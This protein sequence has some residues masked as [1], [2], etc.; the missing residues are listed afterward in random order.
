MKRAALIIL[1]IMLIGSAFAGIDEFYMFNAGTNPYT[2]I[3]GTAITDIL[4]DDALSSAV[5]IG[6]SFP[7]GETLFTEVKVSSN[8]WVGLGTAA[9]G[10][11]LSNDLSSTTAFPYIAPLWDDTSLSSGSCEYL[12]SG[13]AP[14]RIF[15]VQYTNLSWNYSGDNQFNF[16]VKF[17]ENGKIQFNYGSSTGTPNSPSASIGLN[18]VPG[19]TGWFFSVTPGTPSTASTTVSNNSLSVFPPAN[20]LF[21]F[22]PV[23]ASPNDL[24]CNSLTGNTTPSVNT[25]TVY[26]VT[27]RNR[28]TAAQSVYSVKLVTSTGTELVTVAGTPIQPLQTL[29][30]PLTWTPTTQGPLIL[31]GKVVLAGDSNPGNDQSPTLNVTVMPAGMNVVTIG[32]GDQQALIPVNMYYRNSLYETLLY[33]TEIGMVGNISAISLYNNFI[34]DLPNKPI[35]IWLGM[36][37]NA[38]LSAGWIPSTQLTPVFDGTVNFPSGQNSVMIPLQTVFTYTGGNLVMLVNRPMDT[39]YFNWMDYFYCQTVGENRAL[40]I[41]S[42]GTEFDPAAPPV[43]AGLTGQFP[44]MSLYMT[45]L[46]PDPIFI[47][48]P[49]EVLFGQVLMNTSKTRSIAVMNAGGGTLG[50]NSITVSGSPFFTLTGVPTLPQ[51][52]TT[53]Q[54]LNFI[55]HYA[56]TTAGVHT[57]MITI[58]DNITRQTHTIPL[59]ATCVDP[60]IYTL[61]YAQNFDG[62]TAPNLPLEWTRLVQTTSPSAYVRSTVNQFYTG[63]NSIDMYNY[64]DAE[65]GLYLISAPLAAGI[66]TSNMRVKFQGRS[67]NSG[68]SVILGIMTDSQNAASF[69][70]IQTLDVGLA[71]TQYV[72]SLAAYTGTGR[73]IAFKHGGGGTYTNI[74]LDDYLA[75]VIPAN[76]LA[77]LTISGNVTPSVGT[78]TLY[79]VPVFNWGTATQ[80][81]YLVKLYNSSNVELGSAAGT[82]VAA[83]QTVQVQVAWTP[84]VEGLT[85][86]YG[87]VVLTGDENTLNDQSPNYNVQVQPAGTL[88]VTIGDG[89]LDA[90]LP[91]DM[92]WRNSLFETIYY[93]NELGIFGS[94]NTLVFYNNFFTNLPNLPTKIWMGITTQNDLTAGWIPSTQLTLVFDGT[95]SYPS[96]LNTITI[97]LQTPFVYTGGN[98]VML[99]NRPMDTQY[100]DSSDYFKCQTIG[101]NRSLNVQSDG[102]LYDPAAPP[103]GNLSGTFPKTTMFMTALGT[104]PIFMINPT[105]KNYGTVLM[106]TTHNQVFTVTNAGGGPL[107]ISTI[108][109][110]GSEYLTLLGLPALPIQLTTG[111]NFQFTARYNPTVVGVH[112]GTITISDNMAARSSGMRS[113]LNRQVHT[114]ALSGNCIDATIT[115]LPYLQDFNAVTVPELPVTWSKLI[116][117]TTTNTTINST[118]DIFHS[119]ANGV[120]LNTGGDEAPNMLLISPPVVSTTPLNTMRAK[121]WARGS[122]E[123]SLTVGVM[124]NPQDAATFVQLGLI[125]LNPLWTEYVINFSAYTGTGHYVAFKHGAGGMYRSIYLDD[126]MLEVTPQNDLAA[127]SLLGN[128][129]PSV[130]APSIYTVNVFNWGLQAQNTYTVKL[131]KQDGTEIGSAAGVNINPGQT[132]QV[133]VS[134]TPAQEGAVTI[135]AKTV[136][137]ADQNTLNDQSPNFNVVVQPQGLVTITIGAGDQEARIPVDFWWRNSLFET[138]YYPAELS[139]TIGIIYGVSFYNNFPDALMAMPTKVWL[140][141]TTQADLSAG[142]IPSSQ[143][144][145]VFDGTVNYPA[146][147]NTVNISFTTPYMYL[148]GG[149]LVMMVNRPMDTQYYNSGS[150]FKCQTVGETRSLSIYSDSDDFSPSA[151]PDGA[152]NSGQFPKTTFYVIPGGVGHITGTVL[153]AGSQPLADVTV[154][155]QTG[156]YSAITDAQGHYA[157]QNIISDEYNVSFSKFGYVSQTLAANIQEDQTLTLNVTLAQMA[158]VNVTGTILA[159]DTSA[160]LNGAAIHLSGYQDYTANTNATGAFTIPGVYA[161]NEY[162]YS[163]MCPG[164]T[165]ANGTVNVGGTNHNMGSITLLEVAYAPNNVVATAVQTGQQVNLTWEA[166]NPN[167]TELTEGFELTT[168]PPLDWTV[169]VTNTGPA[170]TSGVF[171]TWCRFGNI[172]IGTTPVAPPE[173]TWQAGLWWSYEHQNEWLITPTFNCPPSAYLNFASYVFLGSTAG[174]HYYVK[175]STD[176]GISWTV[177][178]DASAQTGGWNYYA[179]PINIDLSAY[180]GQQL[181]IAWHAVDP[182]SNDGLWYVWFMDDIYIGNARETVRFAWSE[183]Q[184]VSATSRNAR[185]GIIATTQP[186]RHRENGS[187]KPELAL[188]L[189]HQI[190]SNAQDN[191]FLTGYKVWR[192]MQGQEANSAVWTSITPNTITATALQDSQWGSLPDGAYRWAVKAVYTNGV[193]SV[194]SFSNTITYLTETGMI[195]GVVRQQN[196]QPIPGAVITAGDYTATTNNS[197]AYSIVAETGVYSVLVSANNYQGQTVENVLVV[198]NQT[199]TVNFVLIPGS[200]SDDPSAPVAKTELLGNYPNP[201]NPSTTISYALKDPVPV[202]LVIYNLKGQKVK[203]LLRENQSSGRYQVIWNGKDE[204]DRPVGSGVYYYVMKAGAYQSMRKMLLVE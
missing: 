44:K 151:P 82:S 173:G 23:V 77:A 78:Q 66:P 104:D 191:R 184:S 73:Y 148:T 54:A 138:M 46:S 168:F 137:A 162:S 169:N 181:K 196:N 33:P 198:A 119:P 24:T 155:F 47:Y 88:S 180:G 156:G 182:P 189:S 166:P 202:E 176:N 142:W 40:N 11:N 59:S 120:L 127:I 70:P 102:T 164:Y 55:L 199:T 60:T 109:Y 95:V 74:Y 132:V 63:P 187:L 114:V 121:F 141:T 21:E 36:T 163:I 160:G 106:N 10:S 133:P 79:T 204:G 186:S 45:P 69:T 188:P 15:T 61:P 145:L 203:T 125:T 115:T 64:D 48:N 32:A 153:G 89:S 19:G 161:N 175:V 5:P 149:N 128:A 16:Q 165:A 172:T 52:L 144:Q 107:D 105:S 35:K 18:M 86:I 134:W 67:N 80:T 56:P 130:G 3:T 183:M 194:A 27:V 112:T 108:S 14:N 1:L 53:G 118:S 26:T 179:S 101:S 167:A 65:A 22:V 185:P 193:Q 174:D 103:A 197:G 124:T 201:F 116:Q 123:F 49:T 29:T 41:W 81:N 85:T 147:E 39:I 177:L 178:W 135:Y 96:G 93:P 2:S 51:N 12:T 94:I 9:T 92:Y 84:A 171:P 195:S 72:V 122:E 28:G 159:S 113:S 58:V 190:R 20:T 99:V 38:D 31:L 13:T 111:Q 8:G 87:K 25:P 43:G 98:L 4:S 150:V 42:D 140:G 100:Y 7:F 68:R 90:R 143:L 131:F 152:L 97:P 126:V 34:T 157:I 91:V 37:N 75:E 136:L 154:Q 158:M 170:N 110:S 71:W 30:F 117:S 129:T 200:G 6:F 83:G 139:N 62:A 146:G 192:L 50:I 76:D 17:H 57:G